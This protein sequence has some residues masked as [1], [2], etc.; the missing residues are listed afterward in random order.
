MIEIKTLPAIDARALRA[1]L[2][3]GTAVLID[4][5]EPIEYAREHIL[6]ARL[7]PLQA[8]DA[9]DFDRDRG[10]ALVF[11]CKSGNRTAMSAGRIL[12]R[13][14]AEAYALSGGLDA[15]KAAGLPVHVNRNAPM[16]IFRQVQI[17]AGALVLLGVVPG[18]LVS[19][20]FLALSGFVGAGLML[21]GLTGFCGMARLLQLMP[22]NRRALAALAS[23]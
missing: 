11:H 1:R 9:H 16:D 13:G 19:P 23:T 15:W 21:A 5:R 14:F 12:A 10:K 4:I 2:D 20:W 3:A 17:T 7:V 18:V 22:W 6:G 8:L